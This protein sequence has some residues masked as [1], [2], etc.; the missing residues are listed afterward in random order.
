[1]QSFMK[2]TKG[3]MLKRAYLYFFVPT[4]NV[5]RHTQTHRN[6]QRNQLSLCSYIEDK[7]D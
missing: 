7:M 4:A 5:L 1:M 2:D 6:T 3:W